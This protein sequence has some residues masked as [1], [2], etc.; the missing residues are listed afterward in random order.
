MLPQWSPDRRSFAFTRTTPEGTAVWTADA[1][2]SNARR[3]API[4]GGRVSWSPDG[5]RLAVLRKKDGVQQL[6][7]VN[8]AD[9]AAVQLTSGGVPVEDPAWSPDGKHIAVCMEKTEPGN[10]QIH[11]VDPASPAAPRSR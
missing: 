3:V 10:W 7:A 5:S 8:V 6:F 2:G 9:G 4:A 1:D 11:L